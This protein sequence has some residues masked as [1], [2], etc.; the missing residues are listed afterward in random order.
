V[1]VAFLAEVGI[2]FVQ[3]SLVLAVNN[4]PRLARY[5]GLFAGLMLAVYI[6]FEAPLSGMSMN[7]ARSFASAWLSENWTGWWVY[8]TA[9]LLGMF[10]AGAV[11]VRLC[12]AA[13]VRC[14]K[15]HHDNGY[16]GIFCSSRAAVTAS[17]A[18]ATARTSGP[19]RSLAAP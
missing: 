10:A 11:H 14:A 1:P 16:R 2:A 12:G 15:M 4:T 13:N 8:F 17:P 3:M 19:A 18:P 9:P 5:T 7:P 6:S